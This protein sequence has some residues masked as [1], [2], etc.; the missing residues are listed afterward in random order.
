M[1]Q[2]FYIKRQISLT[3]F[4]LVSGFLVIVIWILMSVN[5]KKRKK[6]IFDQHLVLHKSNFREQALHGLIV[7]LACHFCHQLFPYF[8]RACVYYRKWR[9]ILTLSFQFIRNY[10]TIHVLRIVSSSKKINKEDKIEYYTFFTLIIFY[11]MGH[12]IM[13]FLICRISKNSIFENNEKTKI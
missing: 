13:N 1:F 7:T 2:S 6:K 12:V 3:S 9:H 10:S 11:I 8:K 5:S 4:S